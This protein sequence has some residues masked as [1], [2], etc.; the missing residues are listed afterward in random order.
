MKWIALLFAAALFTALVSLV[1]CAG[2]NQPADNLITPGSESAAEP[3]ANP[4]WQWP[5]PSTLVLPP[6]ESSTYV[7][8]DLIKFGTYYELSFPHDNVDTSTGTAHFTPD[9][10]AATGMS[11]DHMAYCHYYFY[12]E[13]YD[14]EP[15]IH[16]GWSV[17]PAIHANAWFGVANFSADSWDWF[18]A[19]NEG[20]ID[21]GSMGAY[22]QGGDAAIIAV[23][24][25][26]TA[27]CNLQY[28]RLGTQQTV[29]RMTANPA[30]GITPLTVE[31][32][33]AS[34]TVEVG[35]IEDYAWDMDGSGTYE[36][37]TGATA[38]TS[39][40]YTKS[41]THTIGLRVTSN[42]GET[43]CTTITFVTSAP[44]T[45]SLGEAA[46]DAF[47]DVV[48]S[49]N[50]VYCAGA[51]GNF[52]AGGKDTLVVKLDSFGNLV[53]AKA[54]GGASD[55]EA[56]GITR[57]ADGNLLVAG[58]TNSYGAGAQDLF[59]QKW[60]PEGSLE[61]TTT[62][63]Q[64][65]AE[66][67]NAIGAIGTDCYVTGYS[68]SFGIGSQDVILVR[69]DTD[70]A[71]TWA[72]LWGG[73]EDEMAEGICTY[74]SF[75]SGTQQIHITGMGR[76]YTDP[77]RSVLFYCK[78]YS[79]ASMGTH[80]IWI[81]NGSMASG[82]AISVSGLLSQEVLVA[83]WM[84]LTGNRYPLLLG[85]S[86]ET[87]SIRKWWNTGDV[88]VC[89]YDMY[90]RGDSV[91]LCGYDDTD[92]LVLRASS[93]GAFEGGLIFSTATPYD[94]VFGVYPFAGHGLVLAGTTS[95]AS[96]GSWTNASGTWED[97]LGTWEDEPVTPL[98]AVGTIGGPTG[99]L[100]DITTLVIDTGGGESDAF[101][102]AIAGP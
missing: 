14:R 27:E 102:S 1:G 16:Y 31:F 8:A 71:V 41:A 36:L 52:G 20:S 24:V 74:S 39:S 75:M 55:E 89:A 12:A 65:A 9:W 25:L 44:W 66:Y 69:F 97:A 3:T 98:E 85:A 82:E 37:E 53:W 64:Q 42:Y 101:V 6:R 61:W 11:I 94:G 87:E 32:S 62:W 29:A 15:E 91:Y 99:T 93:A 80:R 59:V 40:T 49:A 33:G 95:A 83:G 72:R 73:I 67:G 13:D 78:M 21:L 10:S 38:T 68:E 22:L 35:T 51:T 70:G 58:Y 18:P 77:A 86:S 19:N 84:Q 57:D 56:L 90:R 45:H 2:S 92:A 50:Q 88:T 54:W 46:A 4:G 81:P 47:Q 5:S 76:S 28:L 17:P 26:G 34:S 100:T 48:V 96:A 63:G 43:G 7:P 30:G 79:D 23:V 60:T